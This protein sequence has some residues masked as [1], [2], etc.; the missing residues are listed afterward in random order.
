[1]AAETI[2]V[3]L[4]VTATPAA[5]RIP[6]SLP[7]DVSPCSLRKLVSE[8][9]KI[10]LD[11]L[12]L[13][14]R[15]RLIGD[16]E[17]KN[18]VEEFK[19]ED[20]TVLHCMGKPEVGESP[21]VSAAGAPVASAAGAQVTIQPAS[22]LAAAAAGTNAGNSLQAAFATLRSNNPPQAYATAVTTLDKILNNIVSNPM[23]EKYRKMRKQNPAFQK[24][25]G[26]LTG[27]DAAMKG[28]GFIIEIENGEE[29]YV[30]HASAE[31]WPQLM[32]AKAATEAAVRDANAAA[33]QASAPPMMPPGG[34]PNFGGMPGMGMGMPAG[35]S[36]G[37]EQFLSDPNALQAMLQVGQTRFS[38]AISLVF[39]HYL[40]FFTFQESHGSKH[41][42]E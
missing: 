6:V 21:P 1:M 15:G 31:K 32:A 7:K 11:K 41:D 22:N 25:L 37:M 28:A 39:P 13:I 36:A 4:T 24:K 26:G 30:L 12:R 17:D 2:T 9:T 33:N 16:E 27:G 38:V 20:G 18:A 10:P 8:A 35:V 5:P 29:V 19:L 23:E 3:N 40:I 34:M 42:A 14:F